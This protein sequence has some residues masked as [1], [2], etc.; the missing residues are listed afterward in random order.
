MTWRMYPA[1]A[2]GLLAGAAAVAL[3]TVTV[4]G[5]G[6]LLLT[7]LAVALLVEGVRG[8]RPTLTAGDDG[9]T[10]ARLFTREHHPWAAVD[11][12]GAMRP[13]GSGKRLRRSANALEIDLGERL[14]VVSGYRLGANVDDVVA[15]LTS[16]FAS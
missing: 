16:S 12:V 9:I 1:L 14:L 15:A 3:L 7:L 8:L 2:G 6:R 5:P 10:V 4:D 11:G 13:P